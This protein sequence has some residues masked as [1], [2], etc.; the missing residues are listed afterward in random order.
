MVPTPIS[1]LKTVVAILTVDAT[2]GNWALRQDRCNKFPGFCYKKINYTFLNTVRK[3]D[4]EAQVEFSL[5][6]TERAT[7]THYWCNR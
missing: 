3:N 5:K 1:L 4:I 2:I 6:V 7:V